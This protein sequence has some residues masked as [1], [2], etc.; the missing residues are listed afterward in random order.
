MK[1]IFYY[2]CIIVMIVVLAA[3]SFSNSNDKV[4]ASGIY[5]IL[6]SG[7]PEASFKYAGIFKPSDETII[8]YNEESKILYAVSNGTSN[9]GNMM[10][11][12]NV[13]GT[14]QTYHDGE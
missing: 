7:H 12:Y 11:L 9:S 10:P 1:R 8:V 13:N 2:S 4:D 6:V 5:Y 3:C 14:F